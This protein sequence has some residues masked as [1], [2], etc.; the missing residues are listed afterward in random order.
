MKTIINSEKAPKAIGPY[1]VAVKA[2]GF[3]YC[4]GQLGLDPVSGDLVA[5]GVEEQARQALENVKSVL[6]SSGC[7]LA[8]VV[9]TTIFLVDMKDFPAV[10]GVY[11]SYFSAEYPARSTI[12]VAAL[13]KAGLIEIEVIALAK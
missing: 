5:G 6:E 2:N 13:P 1:S 11:G 7:T 10:N 3:V 9:K 4:S 8:D 12:A